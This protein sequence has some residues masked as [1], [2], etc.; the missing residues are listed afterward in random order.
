MHEKHTL[1]HI[2]QQEDGKVEEEEENSTQSTIATAPHLAICCERKAA[3]RGC[4]YRA[5][6]HVTKHSGLYGRK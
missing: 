1:S 2:Q 6:P 4:V 5:D 3:M